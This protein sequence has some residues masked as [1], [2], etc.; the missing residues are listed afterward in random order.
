MPL[1][2]ITREDAKIEKASPAFP[3]EADFDDAPPQNRKPSN[4][5][6]PIHDQAVNNLNFY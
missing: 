3:H 6:E 4:D 5:V 2:A 1:S